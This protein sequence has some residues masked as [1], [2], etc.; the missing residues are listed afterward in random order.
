[1]STHRCSHQLAALQYERRVTW[2]GSKYQRLPSDELPDPELD[3]DPELE[4]DAELLELLE[5]DVERD[6]RR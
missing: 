6:R 2:Y 4:P 1:L 5:G 3:S